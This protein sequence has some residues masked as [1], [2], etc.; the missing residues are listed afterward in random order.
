[1]EQSSKPFE[2]VNIFK[3][4]IY[5]IV[6]YSLMV[7]Y[8]KAFKTPFSD[9]KK[10]FAGSYITFG[11]LLLMYIPIFVIMMTYLFLYPSKN[12]SIIINI[13]M[14][15]L[16]LAFYSV[17]IGFFLTYAKNCIN[18]KFVIPSWTNLTSLFKKGILGMVIMW[19]YS[20][21]LMVIYSIILGSNPFALQ[22]TP[23]SQLA[24]TQ[25]LLTNLG[26]LLSVLVPLYILLYY[27]LPAIMLRYA[28]SEK[29]SGGF[30]F[31]I[32]FRKAFSLKYFVNWLLAILLSIGA[33][34]VFG[35]IMVIL[36]ITIIGI[37]IVIFF[38]IPL[39]FFVFSL[40]IISILAQAYGEVKIK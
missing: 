38:L 3:S 27:L 34:F 11:F 6:S 40:T 4:F 8:T 16:I 33:T 15:L 7:D 28:E 20:I 17:P 12:P 39:F 26:L 10:L 37:P 18:K 36:F 2:N 30:D 19:I 25:A 23:E 9:V 13:I 21:P 24:T 5:G 35:I 14:Y 31:S 29:F 1:M 22:I 32:I